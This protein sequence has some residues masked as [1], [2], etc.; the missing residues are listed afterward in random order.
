MVNRPSKRRFKQ[1]PDEAIH[2]VAL[3]NL[4]IILIPFLLL[5][6]TF[7]KTTILNLYLPEGPPPEEIQKK[8]DNRSKP[9]LIVSIL[10]DGFVLNE[11]EKVLAA[12]PK[13][14]GEYDLDRLSD[15]LLELKRLRPQQEEIILLS[16]PEV[17]YEVLIHAM[18]T[19][20]EAWIEQDGKQMAISLF[21]NVSIG[22]VGEV[23]FKEVGGEERREEK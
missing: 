3:W 20:R 9:I 11:G 17:D 14:R 5:S 22:E 13:T 10:K 1:E 19:S 15:L 7:S 23:I 2:I 21:P 18:D 8:R 12:I 16:E 4:M 6:A